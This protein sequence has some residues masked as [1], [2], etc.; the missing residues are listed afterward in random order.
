MKLEEIV[1][2]YESVH[3]KLW[4]ELSFCGRQGHMQVFLVFVVAGLQGL[5]AD[6]IHTQGLWRIESGMRSSLLLHSLP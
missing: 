2:S 3:G 4:T 6:V 5:G 1:V